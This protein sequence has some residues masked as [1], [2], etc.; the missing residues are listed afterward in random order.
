LIEWL[1]IIYCVDNLIIVVN[2]MT[3]ARVSGLISVEETMGKQSVCVSALLSM[4][5]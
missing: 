1:G 5:Q 3:R 2:R 4:G